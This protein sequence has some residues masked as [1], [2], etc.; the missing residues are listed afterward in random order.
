MA[1]LYWTA[2]F[3]SAIISSYM[4][5]RVLAQAVARH[6]KVQNKKL[7]DPWVYTTVMLEVGLILM[8]VAQ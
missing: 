5:V 6:Y 4:V 8:T 2:K 1:V 7:I 3:K